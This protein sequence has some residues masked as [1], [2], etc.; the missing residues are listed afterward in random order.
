MR[1]GVRL[2]AD[3]YLPALSGP[4]PTI[5]SRTPYESTYTGYIA[6]GIW[7]AQRGYAAVVVDCRGRFE[8]EGRFHAY[9]DDGT[10]TVDALSW[11]ANEPWCNGRIGTQ[12]RSYG[13]LHQWLAAPL[14]SPHLAAMAPHVIMDDYFLD[15]HYVG[16]AF[17]LTLS[18]AAAI[19]FSTSLS[20][21]EAGS[22][23]LFNNRAFMA[24]LPLIEMDELAIGRRIP[25]WREWLEHDRNDGY[26]RSLATTGRHAAITAPAFQQSGWFDA[27][28]GS[29]LRN[30]SGLALG[31][32][33]ETARSRSRVLIGPWSHGLDTPDQLE[34][35]RLGDVDFGHA[36]EVRVADLELRWFDA[37][38][39][40]RDDG[41]LDEP[42]IRLFVMGAN[43]WRDEAEWPIPGTRHDRWFLRSGGVLDRDPPAAEEPDTFIYDPEDPVP[44]LGG[45]NST[46]DWTFASDQPFSPGPVDQRPVEGRHDVLVYS[47]APLERDLEIVGPVE[48]VLYAA[49]SAPDTDFVA[50]L[51]DVHPGGLALNVSEGIV[52]ARYRRDTAN[53]ILLEPGEPD[54]FTIVLYPTAMVFLAGHRIRLDITSSHFPR[55]SRN[56]NT[57]DPIAT[58]TRIVVAR[59]TVLHAS[60]YPSHLVLP[61]APAPNEDRHAS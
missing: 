56:L 1:D 51:V 17:Q 33:S 4:F 47:S 60:G 59:Q 52:R 14:G 45:N 27:Y 28:A 11:A 2:S 49:S 41:F 20:L 38:L 35:R 43:R 15:C 23:S 10:D 19:C 18:V 3:V 48:V 26:W 32:G 24:H 46:G 13:A 44:S 55:F 31:G 50:K 39:R 42:R 61:V 37:L 16:G 58:G 5:V 7:W 25:F 29:A 53:P 54:E 12:G 40:D 36:A 57:G 9:V 30:H 34:A 6:W 21:L 8:S 22:E